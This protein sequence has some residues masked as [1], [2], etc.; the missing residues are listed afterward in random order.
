MVEWTIT[1]LCKRGAIR[2]RRFESCSRHPTSLKLRGVLQSHLTSGTRVAYVGFH[3]ALAKW[4]KMHYVYVLQLSNGNFYVGETGDLGRRMKEH[5][6][7]QER[8]TKKNLPIRL[9][10]YLGFE[11]KPKAM[12]FERYLKTGSGFAFRNKHLV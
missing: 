2:L 1:P 5:N 12:Q 9:V 4:N 10:T 8:T 7:G 11:S 3:E 6:S